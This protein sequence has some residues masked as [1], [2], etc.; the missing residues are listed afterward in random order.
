MCGIISRR[1]NRKKRLEIGDWRLEIGDFYG[2]VVGG[3]ADFEK[4]GSHSGWG[5]A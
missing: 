1:L 4:C 2:Y 5:V 3:F